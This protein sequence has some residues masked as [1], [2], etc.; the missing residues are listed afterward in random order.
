MSVEFTPGEYKAGAWDRRGRREAAAW[1]LEPRMKMKRRRL[2][3]LAWNEHLV[4]SSQTI[5]LHLHEGVRELE[6]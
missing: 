4:S 2:K 1:G 5:F 6:A 3:Y